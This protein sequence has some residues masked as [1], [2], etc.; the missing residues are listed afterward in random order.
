MKKDL[1][2][3]LKVFPSGIKSTK[4]IMQKYAHII[5]SHACILKIF[6]LMFLLLINALIYLGICSTPKESK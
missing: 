3:Q 1:Y 5:E 2:I 4:P 6:G